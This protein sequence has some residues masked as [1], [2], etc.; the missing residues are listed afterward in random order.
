[1]RTRR[2]LLI[3]LAAALGGAPNA[4]AAVRGRR[5]DLE[6]VW[7]TASYTELER[8]RSL[9]RLVV[10][11]AEAAAY[12]A[13]LRALKG[14]APA[15]PGEVGQAENEYIERGEGLARVKGQ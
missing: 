9:P 4:S 3:G 14:M 15:K 7:T 13:P 12:E 10:T 1:M 2:R 6:N 8:P 11:P 5:G